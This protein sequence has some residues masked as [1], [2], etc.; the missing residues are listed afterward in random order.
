VQVRSLSTAFLAEGLP[1]AKRE[2][3]SLA[4]LTP[5]QAMRALLQVNPKDVAKLEARERRKKAAGKKK[6]GK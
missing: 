3:L 4:P 2:K 1:M 5:D 6:R